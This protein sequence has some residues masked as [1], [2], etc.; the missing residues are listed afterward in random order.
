MAQGGT[1]IFIDE[2]IDNAGTTT[3]QIDALSSTSEI[4]VGGWYITKD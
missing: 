4:E 3:M 2:Y 1:K